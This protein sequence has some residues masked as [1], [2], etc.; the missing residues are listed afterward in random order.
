MYPPLPRVCPNC[1][2]SFEP[3]RKN[4]YYCSPDCRI[5]ANNEIAKE[6]YAALVNVTANVDALKVELNRLRQELVAMAASRAALT[7]VIEQVEEVGPDTI[8]YAGAL[9]QRGVQPGRLGLRL[10]LQAGGGLKM[11]EDTIVYRRLK[12]SPHE[13]TYNRIT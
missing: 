10:S 13:Y 6:R 11:G 4:Q 8:R 12:G 7:I 3:G 2:Q 1:R 9:Y 5:E